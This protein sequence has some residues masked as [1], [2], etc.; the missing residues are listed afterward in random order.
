VTE[1]STN[2]MPLFCFNCGRVIA[3]WEANVRT[4][5]SAI[6]ANLRQVKP[7]W[8]S[9]ISPVNDLAVD[10]RRQ[11]LFRKVKPGDPHPTMNVKACVIGAELESLE[12]ALSERNV[13]QALEHAETALRKV[14]TSQ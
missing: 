10:V 13:S 8:E 2:S 6:I 7:H 1:R 3:M 12:A 9:M 5:L 11:N 4:T 14:D